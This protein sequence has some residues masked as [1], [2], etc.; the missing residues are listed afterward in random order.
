MKTITIS[1]RPF[2][3]LTSTNVIATAVQ[4]VSHVGHPDM[5]TEVLTSA[6][7]SSLFPN[8]PIDLALDRAID[9]SAAH[10]YVDACACSEFAVGI[11]SSLYA[12]EYEYAIGEAANAREAARYMA[13]GHPG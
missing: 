10:A 5:H 7:V 8:T 11:Y 2:S 9:M 13:L 3:A 1:T 6:I 4:S 12:A